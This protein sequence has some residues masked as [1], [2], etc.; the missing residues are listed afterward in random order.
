MTLIVM[1]RRRG[2]LRGL[3]LQNAASAAVSAALNPLRGTFPDGSLRAVGV[4]FTDT[5]ANGAANAQTY[6]MTV[7]GR[8]GTDV[9]PCDVW[10]WD[11]NTGEVK[12]SAAFP[13]KPGRLF[14]SDISGA[15]WQEPV[16][17][18]GSATVAGMQNRAVMFPADSQ[19]TCDTFVALTPLQPESLDGTSDAATFFRTA[20]GTSTTLGAWATTLDSTAYAASD[21]A[22]TYEH[23][24]GYLAA[25]IRCTDAMRRRTYYQRFYDTLV[26]QCGGGDDARRIGQN[27]PTTNGEPWTKCYGGADASLP[28]ASTT[29][30]S[31]QETE[32]KSGTAMGY[33]SGYLVTGWKQPWRR[34]AYMCNARGWGSSTV[35]DTAKTFYVRSNGGPRTNLQWG[36]MNLMCAYVIHATMQVSATGGGYGAGRNNDV[37]SFVDDFAF[38]LNALEEY[39][40]TGVSAEYDGL[41][42]IR[43]TY[44]GDA[45]N[46]A[47]GGDSVGGKFPTFMQAIIARAL[48][49]FDNNIYRD[50]RVTTWLVDMADRVMN[51]FVVDGVYVG[52]TYYMQP[53]PLSASDI[54][55][56]DWWNYAAFH[57]ELLSW[58]YA[59]TANTTY[60]NAAELAARRQSLIAPP[61]GGPQ[62]ANV[63]TFGE[64]FGGHLQSTL[65]YLNGGTP[66]PIAGAHPTAVTN[67]PTYTS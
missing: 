49:F 14:L 7:M 25:A 22:S 55:I 34:I 54:T 41:V 52:M 58:A 60:K 11:G 61:P 30:Q 9:V 5:L 3:R 67:P 16:F 37:A 21:G 2:G 15:G 59:F 45:T 33:T 35:Y 17:N 46:T 10:R 51:Q 38:L 6:T 26:S 47:A 20:D 27:F 42:G 31:A 40:F 19:Y 63:K 24:H 66:R 50:T 43:S 1:G 36:A 28:A 65:F 39:R 32:A 18:S 64:F 12:V 56:N 13:L 23:C 53:G 62:G 4:Q 8:N 48:I 57:T 44:N 29:T